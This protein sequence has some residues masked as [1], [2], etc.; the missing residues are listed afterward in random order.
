MAMEPDAF[1]RAVTELVF[2]SD[3]PVEADMLFV[4]GSSH[5]EPV[6]QAA[7]LYR[8]GLAPRILPSGLYGMGVDGFRIPPWESEC[9]WMC[10]LLAA[11]GIPEDALLRE[12]RARCTWDNA[13]LS[14]AVCDGAGLK[15]RRALICCRP[16]HARR[17][18]LYYQ[19]A[20]PEAE[21]RCVPCREEGVNREDWFLTPEGRRRVLGEVRRLGDQINVQ[22]EELIRDERRE[23]D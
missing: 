20:F 3:P 1:L 5:R 17:A 6:M 9:A 16:F 4:P 22:L 11:E 2:V 13:R 21:L 12:D 18:K 10:G 19:W 7:A 15:I 23:E 8:Q 14:R